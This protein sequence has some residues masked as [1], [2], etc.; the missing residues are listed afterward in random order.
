MRRATAVERRVKSVKEMREVSA[1]KRRGI[2]Q[3]LE[4]APAHILP[5]STH[6]EYG[7][8]HSG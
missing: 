4:I 7:H 6:L 3:L 8:T 5:K 1:K 2:N